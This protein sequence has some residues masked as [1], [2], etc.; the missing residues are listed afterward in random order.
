[1]SKKLFTWF[2]VQL[3]IVALI[4]VGWLAEHGIDYYLLPLKDRPHDVMHTLLKPG[5][6]W[7]HGYGIIGSSMILLLFIYSLRKRNFLGLRF[8]KIKN[9]LKPDFNS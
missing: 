2:A 8:G 7:G 5:G 9:W 3:Y 1:M 4:G 6:L